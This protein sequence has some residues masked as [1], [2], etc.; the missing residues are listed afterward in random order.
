MGLNTIDSSY[1]EQDGV[2]YRPPNHLN[3]MKR[4]IAIQ[5]KFP[6]QYHGEDLCWAMALAQSGLL[7]TEETITEPYYFYLCSDNPL[8]RYF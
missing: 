2:Y 3:P 7:K 8:S 6:E 5:F 1:F 4:E